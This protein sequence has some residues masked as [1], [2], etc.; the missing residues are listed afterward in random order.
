[1]KELNESNNYEL[2]NKNYKKLNTDLK[3]EF[4]MHNNRK[5]KIKKVSFNPSLIAQEIRLYRSPFLFLLS[6]LQKDE[7]LRKCT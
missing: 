1:M 2:D 3:E 7:Y 4:I 6:L 5:V